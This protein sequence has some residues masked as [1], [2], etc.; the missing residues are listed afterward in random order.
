MKYLIGVTLIGI[1]LLGCN[2]NYSNCGLAY[3]GGEI[4][5]PNN[6]H[7]ILY[8]SNQPVDT[9]YLDENDRF[10]QKI[11][12]LNPGLYSFVHGDEYQVVLLEPN[13]SIMI[14]LNTFDFDE[15]LVFSGKGSKKN[16]YLLGLFVGMEKENRSLLDLAKESDAESFEAAL[17]SIAEKK[18][19][20]LAKFSEKYSVSSLFLKVSNACIDFGNY[21]H[22]EIYPFRYYGRNYTNPDLIP[23]EFYSYRENVDYNDDDLKDFY[24]Y[25]NFLFP[26]FS[27]LALAKHLSESNDTIFDR[28]AV[29]Y[30]LK[31]L[32]L[33]DS[34][35]SNEVIKNNL[36]KYSTRNFLTNSGSKM[37][38]E[39]VYTSFK[40]KCSNEE[41]T[42]YIDEFYTS[43]SKL[44]T[45][46]PIPDIQL[47]DINK[48]V[49][50]INSL[51]SGPTVVYFWS[52]SN[53][54]HAEESHEKAAE[55]ADAFPSINFV[56]INVN[57]QKYESWKRL[58]GQH[59]LKSKHEFMLRDPDKA[60]KML[61]LYN[62]YK[63]MV[64]D[65]DKKILKSNANLFWDDMN[66]TLAVLAEKAVY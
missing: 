32:Q 41:F 62:I 61:A 2:S 35:I 59:N 39:A 13:D 44:E 47:V 42:G 11:E 45:G 56:S 53:V 22:K 57:S 66:E 55:L 7:V 18:R 40:E 10:F 33:I 36:L 49:V 65:G 9:L 20:K 21:A 27:N 37:D 29:G 17:D 8:D 12:N 50:D 43:L 23:A 6:D 48:N 38:N 4:I 46:N 3:F 14:R 58:M 25:Y 30:N 64:I 26:H 54:P 31:K 5:N 52:K 60:A 34:L 15:S 1:S 28:Y 19:A 51:I 24:P 63:V 16:N